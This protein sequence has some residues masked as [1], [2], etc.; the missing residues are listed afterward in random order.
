MQVF[1]KLSGNQTR[2]VSFWRPRASQ[3]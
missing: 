3:S 1:I 2:G